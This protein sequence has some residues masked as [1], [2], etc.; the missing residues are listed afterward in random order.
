MEPRLRALCDLAVAE[1]REGGRPARVRRP[2]AG[3]LPA[4]AY[5]AGLAALRARD[6]DPLRP[7]RRG[8]SVRLRGTPCGSSTASW[9]C[10]A[11]TRCRICPTWTWP[12][13][14]G[15]TRRPSERAEARRRHLAAVAGRGRRGDRRARPGQR[16]GRRRPLLG[17][18]RG[19]AGRPRP[20]TGARSSGAALAAHARLVA[21]LE[22]AAEHRRPGRRAARAAPAPTG[23]P[24]GQSGR[25]MPVDLAA[26]AAEADARAR[27]ADR[28]C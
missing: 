25:R 21:H 4:T 16:A 10:T 3:P 17:A 23:R 14:T 22:R 20:G 5:A 18:V 15:S 7:V 19:L 11:A 6:A 1:S 26:L 2:G 28:R 27:P 24:D 8:A 13:T 9:S 12:A